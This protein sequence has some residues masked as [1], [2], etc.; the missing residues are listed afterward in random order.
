MN[1]RTLSERDICTKFITPALEKAGWNMYT[2][3][4]EEVSF[5]AGKIYVR[6]KVTARGKGKRADYILYYKPNIPIALIEVKDNNHSARAGIQQALDYATIL[7]IPCVFSTNGDEFLFHN[8]AEKGEAIETTINLDAFPS[9]E[10][11]WEVYKRYKGLETPVAERIASQ[12]YYLDASGRAP[13]YYQQIAVN[14]TIEAIARGQNRILLIM[15]TGTGKT[16]TA[17]QI[18]YRLWKAGIKKRILFLAD[19]NALLTQ[20]KN[21]DFRHFNDKITIVKKRQVDKS[22]EIYLALYQGISGSEEEKNI[23]KQFSSGFFDLIIVDECHRGSAK[24]DS[25]W[26]EILDYFKGATQIGLTATPKETK[27]TSNIEYLAILYTPI[28]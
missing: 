12:D 6:G 23:Y 25:A 21:G 16:Y 22:Y 8:R 20:T 26:R 13:R 10:Q 19:R 9:P 15:A 28:P 3:F 4:L 18:V 7:D 11:L 17:Y 5:T 14:R 27:D 2:Q 1:K 24:E